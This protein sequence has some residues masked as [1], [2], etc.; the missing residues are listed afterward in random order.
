MDFLLLVAHGSRKEVANQEVRELAARIEQHG[1]NSYQAVIP[2]FL[3]FA[4]PDVSGGIDYCAGLGAKN[5]TVVP[6]FLSAG[7]HVNRDVP[8][9]LQTARLRHPKINV[10]VTQHFGASNGI[11][12]SIIDCASNPVGRKPDQ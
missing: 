6:Y 5:I 12:E 1:T 11:V 7:N 9:Q 3:E 2:A 10:Q 4:E 8:D